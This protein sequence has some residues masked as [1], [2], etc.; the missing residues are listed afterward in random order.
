VD[1]LGLFALESVIVNIAS[2]LLAHSE[3]GALIGRSLQNV[4]LALIFFG[5]L[6]LRRPLVLYMARQFATGNDPASADS[7]DRLA[8]KPLNLQVYRLMTWVWTA[9]LLIKSAGGVY[10]AVTLETKTYLI[11]S[12]LWDLLSDALLVSW[13]LLYGKARLSVPSAVSAPSPDLDFAPLVK[14]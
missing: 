5:S 13:S 2:L 7:F 6:A 11:A 9:G 3:K 8:L 14:P 12:P 1:F 10:L 4:P